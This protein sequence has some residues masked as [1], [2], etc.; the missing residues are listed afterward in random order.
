MNGSE[1]WPPG[2]RSPSKSSVPRE[3]PEDPSTNNPAHWSETDVV[4]G[5]LYRYVDE[6]INFPL[7][8]IAEADLK[9]LE[10]YE[11][12]EPSWVLAQA[13]TLFAIYDRD[14]KL[15]FGPGGYADD[16]SAD[17]LAAKDGYESV[18]YYRSQNPTP[19]LETPV[20]DMDVWVRMGLPARVYLP[21]LRKKG[22]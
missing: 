11:F 6:E 9:R 20:R 13:P 16:Y 22:V 8:E 7:I 4:H 15:I 1:D 18:Q 21:S 2:G 3:W 5:R 12:F 10:G 14:E 17:R 19:A